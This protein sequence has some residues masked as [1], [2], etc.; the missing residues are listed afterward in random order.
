M[1]FDEHLNKEL[2]EVQGPIGKGMGINKR[3]RGV[4]VAFSTGTGVLTFIDLAV[5]IFL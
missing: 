2:Y 3:S 4:H 1:F 5:R